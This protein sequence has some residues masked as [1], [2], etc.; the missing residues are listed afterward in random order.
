MGEGSGV[1]DQGVTKVTMFRGVLRR[2]GPE[3]V[4]LEAQSQGAPPQNIATL[5]TVVCQWGSGPK[6]W[7]TTFGQRLR[8]SG[9]L[10]GVSSWR[11]TR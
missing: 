10:P 4:W 7:G 9:R 2:R 11:G 3:G 8:V 1:G 6:V 5:V